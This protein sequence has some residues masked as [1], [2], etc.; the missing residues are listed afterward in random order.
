MDISLGTSHVWLLTD[1]MNHSRHP[2]GDWIWDL[3]T[4]Y[5]ISLYMTG[6]LTA[7]CEYKCIRL[8]LVIA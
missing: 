3:N 1:Q 7:V 6:R 2:G 8:K 5:T 4:L